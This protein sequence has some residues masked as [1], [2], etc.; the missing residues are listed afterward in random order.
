MPL[1]AK[2]ARAVAVLT[3]MDHLDGVGPC[4]GMTRHLSSEELD[5]LFE[6]YFSTWDE[7]PP[8]IEEDAACPELLSSRADLMDDVA[9]AEHCDREQQIVRIPGIGWKRGRP[10]AIVVDSPSHARCGGELVEVLRTGG[11]SC[12]SEFGKMLCDACEAH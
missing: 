10:P 7:R 9:S 4:L 3:E 1:P 8:A 11:R 5:A 12:K 2:A 6:E